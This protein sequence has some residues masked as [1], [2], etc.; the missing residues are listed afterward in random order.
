MKISNLDIYQAEATSFATKHPNL[1]TL[2]IGLSAEVGEL[3]SERMKELRND[4]N[5]PKQEDIAS[6]L[7]DVLWYV[8]TIAATYNI[9]L[10]DIATNNVTKLN[11]RKENN[12]DR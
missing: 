9:Q 5:N 3:C 12:Y 1:N 11:T 6:E 2:F 7:G 4:R 8:A 10:S